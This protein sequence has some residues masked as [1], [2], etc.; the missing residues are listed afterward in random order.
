[1]KGWFTGW[2]YNNYTVSNGGFSHNF[3]TGVTTYQDDRVK[4][5]SDSDGNLVFEGS[6]KGK[7][8]SCET[9]ATS[10]GGGGIDR[11][12]LTCVFRAGPLQCS[13]TIDADENVTNFDWGINFDDPLKNKL[14]PHISVGLEAADILQ[15]S[16]R[17]TVVNRGSV[18]QGQH[19]ENG[20]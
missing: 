5:V 4:V 7:S 6:I 16:L 14:S 17:D 3:D 9:S 19:E 18:L 12:S 10:G 8:T 2:S 11:G 15:E 20:I 13:A 1:M